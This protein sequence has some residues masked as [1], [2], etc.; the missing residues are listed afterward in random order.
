MEHWQLRSTKFFTSTS[1]LVPVLIPNA[2]LELFET[3]FVGRELLTWSPRDLLYGF[4]LQCLVSPSMDFCS[5]VLLESKYGQRSRSHA[6][7]WDTNLFLV[8]IMH[9][10]GVDLQG[11]HA[12]ALWSLVTPMSGARASSLCSCIRHTLA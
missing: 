4:V 5:T 2:I 11:M 6:R 1:N 12:H 3:N 9:T 8:M 7:A 10:P